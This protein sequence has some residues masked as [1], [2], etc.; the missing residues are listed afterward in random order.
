MI[1]PMTSHILENARGT[2]KKGMPQK[3]ISAC[4][5]HGFP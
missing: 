3:S 4:F 1:L 5:W 2:Q